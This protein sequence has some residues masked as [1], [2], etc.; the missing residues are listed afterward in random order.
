MEPNECISKS[1]WVKEDR[2]KRVQVVWFFLWVQLTVI[3]FR[4]GVARIV[5]DCK[6]TLRELAGSGGNILQW[7]H[8]VDTCQNSLSWTLKMSAFYSK[9]FNKIH[10]KNWNPLV[11]KITKK[12]A[13]TIKSREECLTQ[14]SFY[15]TKIIYYSSPFSYGRYEILNCSVIKFKESANFDS[16]TT[17]NKPFHIN[18]FK[19]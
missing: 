7:F 14:F 2:H 12:I 5:T 3:Q 19:L 15:W 13:K 16:N 6:V 18:T 9:C 4:S 11:I 17:M 1:Y 10:L 8:S